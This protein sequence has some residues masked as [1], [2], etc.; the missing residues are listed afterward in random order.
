[1]CPS[2]V[3]DIDDT[4]NRDDLVVWAIASREDAA[5]LEDFR[6]AYDVSLPILVDRDGRVADQYRMAMAYPTAAYPQEWLIDREGRI[7]W[8]ANRYDRDQLEAQIDAL[9]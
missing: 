7:A 2:E 9:E 3:S 4:L 6:D 1:M 5:L 8:T